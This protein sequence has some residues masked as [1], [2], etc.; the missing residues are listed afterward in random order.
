MG[1]RWVVEG[2]AL[3]LEG[4]FDD[5]RGG[6]ALVIVKGHFVGGMIKTDSIS[7]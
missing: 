5:N 7:C 4:G 6:G 1:S 3:G 2:L